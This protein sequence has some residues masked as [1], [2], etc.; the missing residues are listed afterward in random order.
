MSTPKTKLFVG[1]LPD[2][3]TDD[4]LRGLFEKHGEVTECDVINKYGFVH[5]ATPEQATEAVKQ[6]N[7]YSFMGAVI[8]VEVISDTYFALK[9]K[10]HPEPGA[11]G[12]ANKQ[13][14]MNRRGGG[15]Q[16]NGYGPPRG[17]YGGGFSNG[18]SRRYDGPPMGGDSYYDRPFGFG[19]ERMRP[20]PP[21]F[22][23]RSPPMVP[24]REDF[25]PRRPLPPMS[26][27]PYSRPPL[28][29]LNIRDDLYERRPLHER[30][31]YLY[32]RRSPPL[33]SMRSPY[34]YDSMFN[35]SRTAQP[36]TTS[37]RLSYF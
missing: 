2:G 14:V 20:Y 28:P 7:N 32:S 21:P 19:R 26:S 23:R 18:Y 11:P 30:S 9:S 33:S 13:T 15:P 34:G 10:L 3:C 35:S 36:L 12:R 17:G 16:R 24:M 31:D 22:E 5:M 27:D 25:A 1:H 37:R 6:L 4:D 8:S 29:P